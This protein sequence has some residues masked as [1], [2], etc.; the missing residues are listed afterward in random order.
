MAFKSHSDLP[1]LHGKPQSKG[2]LRTKPE[3][4][5]VFELLPFSPSGE[6][7]HLMLYIEKEGVNTVYVARALARFFGVKDFSKKGIGTE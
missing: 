3:D 6:G 1:Y 7:E 5:K 2:D 4:F